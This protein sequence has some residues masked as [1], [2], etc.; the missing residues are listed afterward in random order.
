MQRRVWRKAY[1]PSS[2]ISF[3]SRFSSRTLWFWAMASANTWRKRTSQ[4]EMMTGGRR[5]SAPAA[6][7]ALCARL[8]EVIVLLFFRSVAMAAAPSRSICRCE[9]VQCPAFVALMS[10]NRTPAH[11]QAS[12]WYAAG[13]APPRPHAARWYGP[14]LIIAN[15]DWRIRI[16]AAEPAPGTAP[17]YTAS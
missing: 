1:V 16:I 17:A 11:A 12:A 7:I 10:A 13:Y 8:S 5:T 15:F 2:P 14:R 4:L 9:V 6:R 3:M